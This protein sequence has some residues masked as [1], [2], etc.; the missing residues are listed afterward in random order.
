MSALG[1]DVGA[2]E[3]PF[4]VGGVP[5]PVPGS[6][7]ESRGI[8]DGGV[9]DA[10]SVISNDAGDRRL[11]ARGGVASC[12]APAARVA[13]AL[14]AVVSLVGSVPAV[15]LVKLLQ[16]HLVLLL[17][18]LILGASPSSSPAARHP[19]AAASVAQEH[20]RTARRGSLNS[21]PPPVPFQNLEAATPNLETL[22]VALC[23]PAASGPTP[24]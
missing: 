23:T 1:A 13:A 10:L 11:A 7:E 19:A 5:G 9:S 2:P 3:I 20:A 4:I 24:A 17:L 18:A 14:A 8:D 16:Q 21:P 22:S 6:E 12:G 15:K